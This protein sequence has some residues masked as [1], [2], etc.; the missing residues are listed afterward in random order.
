MLSIINV[1]GGYHR[2][3]NSIMD[4]GTTLEGFPIT[5]L[6]HI[7]LVRPY[8]YTKSFTT[9]YRGEQARKDGR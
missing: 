4:I 6:S 8:A 1:V 5:L 9:T 2:F 3:L 7:F